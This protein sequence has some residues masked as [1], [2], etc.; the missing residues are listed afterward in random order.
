[1]LLVAPKKDAVGSKV[2]EATTKPATWPAHLGDV[3][4]VEMKKR[5]WVQEE[6]A[7]FFAVSQSTMSR[8]I[9]GEMRPSPKHVEKIAKFCGLDLSDAMRLNY[10]LTG[11]ATE[12]AGLAKRMA[13]LEAALLDLAA[14]TVDTRN[15]QRVLNDVVAQLLEKVKTARSTTK[16]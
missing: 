15:Q 13:D 5:G 6:L 11:E 10:K 8:W 7:K 12:Y 3:L 16:R 9:S 14:E 1:M 2:P 4:S